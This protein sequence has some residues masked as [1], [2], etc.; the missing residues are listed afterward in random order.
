MVRRDVRRS[1]GY[2]HAERNLALI[3]RLEAGTG[4]YSPA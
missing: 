2:G 1:H 3:R 4:S